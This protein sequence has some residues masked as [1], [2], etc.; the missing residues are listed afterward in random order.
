VIPYWLL[1]IFFAAGALIEH[2]VEGRRPRSILLLI[3]ALIIALMIGF[4]FKVGADW[5]AYELIFNYSKLFGAA[6][7]VQAFGDP[8]YSLLTW[9]VSHLGGSIWQV[10]LV[11]G[12]I[13]SWGLL[14]FARAQTNPWL[15]MTVAIPYLV[16]VVA[17]GYSRQAVAIGILL[18]GLA[19]V[20][21]GG[22][23]LRFAGYVA[24]AAL[25]H[26]TAVIVLP[27]V[28][29]A[30]PR[31]RMINL[32]AGIALT[33]LFYDFFLSQ[34]M[35]V[36]YRNYIKSEYSSQGAGVRVALNVIP[37]L[38]YLINRRNFHLSSVESKLWFI[39]SMA[40]FGFF[41]LFL[42]SPS[43][44][45]VDRMNLYVMPIQIA[46]WSRVHT[47]YNLGRLGRVL[48]VALSA[49]ILFTWLNFAVF[50]RAWVPYQ[51]YPLFS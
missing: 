28:A 16:V 31:S 22:S 2:D 7:S 46:V 21:N 4:R 17:M 18:A 13:F 34:S 24:A 42:I 48:V 43:S 33:V 45:A 6:R 35:N 32:L 8:A 14:R 20:I 25:F 1:F 11:C 10:N 49:V 15:A 41:G 9:S 29:F 27:L 26:K 12:L 30:Q 5:I 38:L 36:L 3:G 19:S 23:T 39:F 47:A 40:S 51:F 37:S 50:S 44:T